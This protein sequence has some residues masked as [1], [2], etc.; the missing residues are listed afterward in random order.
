M[1]TSFFPSRYRSCQACCQRT[2]KVRGEKVVQHYHRAVVFHLI[3]TRVQ[4]PLDL[5]MIRP[6]EGEVVAAKRLL[7]RVIRHHGRLFDVVLADAI[8]FE[9]PFFNFCIDHGK[10]VIAVLKGDQRV[11]LQDAQGLFSMATAQAW[12]QACQSVRAWDDEGFT[13]AEGIKVPLRVVHTEENHT[14][15]HRKDKGWALETTIHNWWWVTTLPSSNLPTRT[16]WQIAHARWKIENNLFHTLATYWALDHCFKHNPT[17][18]TNFALTLFIAFLLLQCFYERN[19]K[20]QRRASLTL[21]ALA[22]ELKVEL[23][24][25]SSPAPWLGRGG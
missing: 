14:R 10:H 17:A 3:G 21:I 12:V 9:S 8:Y 15:R 24:I 19:L 25:M 5:E 1:A 13:S 22:E 20:P 6:G 11:L 7:E 23:A 4:A 16:F 18:I 2:V